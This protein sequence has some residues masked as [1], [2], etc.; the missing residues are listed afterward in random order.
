LSASDADTLLVRRLDFR[1]TGSDPAFRL[2]IALD[3]NRDGVLDPMEPLLV[4]S[5]ETAVTPAGTTISLALPGDT[6]RIPRGGTVDVLA[7]GLLSGGSPNGSEFTA[8]LV[9]A[10]SS[11]EGA[12]SG[13]SV[14]FVGQGTGPAVAR[15]TLLAA[16]EQLNLT[17]N[18]VRRSPLILNF[19]PTRRIEIYDFTGRLTQRFM[20]AASDVRV[21][22]DLR[23]TGGAQIANGVYVIVMELQSGAVLR[24]KLF[25]AR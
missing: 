5:A 22:W 16:N 12:R 4:T 9:A 6:L 7:V 3:V 10:T 11:A 15:T 2:A 23:N 18:P 13:A 8:T 14:N 17:Q 19:Q 20:P 24:Q 25:V 1:I 21:E